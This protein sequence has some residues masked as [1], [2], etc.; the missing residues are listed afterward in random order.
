MRGV[1]K[2]GRVLK[3][4]PVPSAST[5]VSAV[6]VHTTSA[7]SSLL[8][9]NTLS[10]AGVPTQTA[11][12]TAAPGAV[13]T[14]TRKSSFQGGNVPS[15]ADSREPTSTLG[16]PSRTTFNSWK[17]PTSLGGLWE[18]LN[19]EGAGGL[20]AMPQRAAQT[21]YTAA[22]MAFFF[23]QSALISRSLGV[24]M[25]ALPNGG[26]MPPDVSKEAADKMVQDSLGGIVELTKMDIENVRRGIYRAPYDMDPRHRQWS[27]AF[28]ADQH[29]RLLR[30]RREGKEIRLKKD[31]R[32][33]SASEADGYPAY[34]L[35]HFHWQPGG[36]LSDES[37]QI[38]EHSTESLFFGAQDMMQRQALVPLHYFMRGRDPAR[39]S[40]LDVACGT[41]RFLTFLKDN[42]PAVRTYG[43][44]LS[45][46]YLK[47][48]EANM[49]Y[50]EKFDMKVNGSRIFSRAQFIQANAERLPF[51]D[52]SLD[53]V[54]CVY[55]FHELPPNARQAVAQEVSR[56]LKPGGIFIWAD[57]TQDGDRPEIA[58]AAGIFNRMFHEPYFSSFFRADFKPMF[59]ASGLGHEATILA[60]LTKV[61]CFRKGF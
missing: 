5:S 10:P 16:I 50:F 7:S 38:Y 15:W 55:L 58:Q 26:P 6:A 54:T 18:M 13:H 41:G 11:R 60:H 49:G 29:E 40:V 12:K 19:L 53:V 3:G 34:Y 22:R 47:T 35:Q 4:A 52:S 14:T 31:T 8:D 45:P 32:V 61:M 51:E 59:A 21:A 33:R 46:N 17:P 28:W 42:Y 1:I 27:P 20:S 24:E 36:W 37:A 44:D 43:V 2:N 56:V 9:E 30:D 23:A 25:S 48:A 39:T 57:A